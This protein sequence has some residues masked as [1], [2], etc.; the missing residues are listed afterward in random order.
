MVNYPNER[1]FG[2][3]SNNNFFQFV[4]EIGETIDKE[5]TKCESESMKIYYL[6]IIEV[7]FA[8]NKRTLV[9]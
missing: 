5:T 8:S 9:G 4:A 1:N 7:I 6:R 3:N 2:R